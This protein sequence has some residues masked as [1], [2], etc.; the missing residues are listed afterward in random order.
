MDRLFAPGM[1]SWNAN[2]KVMAEL[3]RERATAPAHPDFIHNDKTS[4]GS[5]ELVEDRK[6]G[7]DIN[8]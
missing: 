4:T 7:S 5:Q 1:G 6:S 8:V 3:Q 2:K